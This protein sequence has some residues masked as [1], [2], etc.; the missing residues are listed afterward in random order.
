MKIFKLFVS[1]F[2]LATLSCGSHTNDELEISIVPANQTLINTTMFSC[3]DLAADT[4]PTTG[5]LAAPSFA[6]NQLKLTW[7]N[8]TRN[9]H[10]VSLRF[11]FKHPDLTGGRFDYTLPLE[12][13]NSMVYDSDPS[14]CLWCD[15]AHAMASGRPTIITITRG[16]IF[17]YPEH[18]DDGDNVIPEAPS[19]TVACG[20]RAGAVPIKATVKSKRIISGLLLIQGLSTK[21]GDSSNVENVYYTVPISL[22]FTPPPI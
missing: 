3:Q 16:Q 8:T 6:V 7:K 14:K 4:M 21:V 15:I 22:E 12:E 13:L 10:V 20:L 9:L 19:S 5:T 2:I 1:F 18:Y 17:K 11:V